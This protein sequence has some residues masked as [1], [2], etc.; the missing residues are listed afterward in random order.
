MSWVWARL[1][2]C[3]AQGPSC[4]EGIVRG[5]GFIHDSCLEGAGRGMRLSSLQARLQAARRLV[6]G[7]RVG[8][9]STCVQPQ[10]QVATRTSVNL[11]EKEGQ[12][13]QNKAKQSIF[14]NLY[15]LNGKKE[16]STVKI[17]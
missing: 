13:L 1:G 7:Q 17:K 12:S 11:E 14:I 16:N 15:L 6:E 9:G 10:Q 5:V 8:A 3:G 2:R 4:S